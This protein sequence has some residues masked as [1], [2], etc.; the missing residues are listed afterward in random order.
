ML[1]YKLS[2]LKKKSR[3]REKE[4]RKDGGILDRY[5]N[6]FKRVMELIMKVFEDECFRRNS[7][8]I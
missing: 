6:C 1:C 7:G 2:F 8:S 3:D 4:C 5:L